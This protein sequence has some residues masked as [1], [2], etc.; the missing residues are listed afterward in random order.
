MLYETLRFLIFL[1]LSG[2]ENCVLL[3]TSR[4]GNDVSKET[5]ERASRLGDLVDA[6]TRDDRSRAGFFIDVETRDRLTRTG[7]YIDKETR[8]RMDGEVRLEGFDERSIRKCSEL[9]VGSAEKS[10]E[11]LRQAKKLNIWQEG[12]DNLAREGKEMPLLRVPI[13]LL[14]VCVL[15]DQNETLPTRKTDMVSTLLNLIMDRTTLKKHGCLSSELP[16]LERL[17][18]SLGEAAWKA[19]QNDVQQL[20]LRTVRVA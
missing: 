9:Y 10:S 4:P 16:E 14:M 19:L 5:R 7:N 6:D 3:L 11:L 13:F 15:F 8:D 17:L 20:L 12:T 18:D 1:H 2:V